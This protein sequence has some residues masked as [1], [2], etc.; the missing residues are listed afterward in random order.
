MK[1][2]AITGSLA[3]GKT[4]AGKIFSIKGPVFSSDKQVAKLYKKKN[5]KKYIAK[6]FKIK[7]ISNIKK[8]IRDKILNNEI[9][10][11]KLE[12]IIHPYVKIE[13]NK[14]IKKNKKKLFIFFEIPLLVE[15][16]LMKKFDIT[17]FIR[18]GKNIRLKRFINNGGNKKLFD[19]LNNK[20]LSD[21]KKRKFCDH[22]VVNEKDF[23]IL[24]KK[25][26]DILNKHE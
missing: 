17:I 22:T 25:L 8:K 6:K 3:S 13:R 5:F 4:T 18:A 20:Q 26:F 16:K 12:K 14:F 11:N 19:I 1:K 21:L 15:R 2:I 24:K 9:N 23:K 7:N 10:I